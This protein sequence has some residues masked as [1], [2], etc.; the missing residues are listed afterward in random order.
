M[1]VPSYLSSNHGFRLCFLS[2]FILFC[3]TRYLF[4]TCSTRLLFCVGSTCGEVKELM[5]SELCSDIVFCSFS[6]GTCAEVFYVCSKETFVPME[7]LF[8]SG[9]KIGVVSGIGK[10]FLSVYRV[11]LFFC[12]L[13]NRIFFFFR[14]TTPSYRSRISSWSWITLTIRWNVFLV[15]VF[16]CLCCINYYRWLILFF[17][18]FLFRF[19]LQWSLFLLYRHCCLYR[20]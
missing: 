14:A 10:Q 7:S 13:F 3:W 9:L 20:F 2:C 18:L 16:R 6:W 5:V 8:C 15:F 1:L 4:S 19:N 17:N 12:F 11:V